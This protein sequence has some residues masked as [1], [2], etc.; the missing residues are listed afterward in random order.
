MKRLLLI[1]TLATV[2]LSSSARQAVL[3][4]A[5]AARFCKLMVCDTDNRLLS[6]HA[7]LSKN[8]LEASDSLTT[9]QLFCD[10]VF[11]YDGW[12]TLRI[13]PYTDGQHTDWY[14]AG[15]ELPESIPSEHRRYMQEVLLRMQAEVDAEHW[16]VVDAYIDRLLQYQH[17]FGP[18]AP[19]PRTTSLPIPL[20]TT[21]IFILFL[22]IPFWKRK[23][24][25]MQTIA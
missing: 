14:A 6:L 17:Q 20:I 8:P 11:H 19:A 9:E 22:S 12:Q 13:F 5:T 7:F 24:P 15:S 1:L 10:F 18:V 2:V 21:S 16:D 4:Q 25:A 3:P 23:K